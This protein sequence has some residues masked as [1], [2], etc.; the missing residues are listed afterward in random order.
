MMPGEEPL[1]PREKRTEVYA[2]DKVQKAKRKYMGEPPGKI[3]S[4]TRCKLQKIWGTEPN[5]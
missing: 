3:V 5:T 1:V 4:R 2:K